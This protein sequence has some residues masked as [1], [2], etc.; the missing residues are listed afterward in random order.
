MRMKA[1]TKASEWTLCLFSYWQESIYDFIDVDSANR[2]RKPYLTSQDIDSII[3]SL[4]Y[5]YR[6]HKRI[7]FPH[8]EII[9]DVKIFGQIS[10]ASMAALFCITAPNISCKLP[11]NKYR[12]LSNKA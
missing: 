9:N 5:E 12:Y 10:L 4:K 2:P 8:L 3:K 1:L 6:N 7:F 11:S